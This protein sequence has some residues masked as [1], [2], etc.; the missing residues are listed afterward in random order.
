M[1]Q[2]LLQKINL[3]K[4][5]PPFLEALLEVLAE[6]RAKG[7]D[8]KVYS[9]WRSFA[10]QFELYKTFLAGGAR[11]AAPGRSAHN[12]G[13]A[14]DCARLLPDK[15]LSWDPKDYRV[16]LSVLPNYSLKSGAAYHDMPHINWPGYEGAVELRPLDKL[17]RTTDGSEEDK[18]KAVWRYLDGK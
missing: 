1:P 18:L 8:Y 10:E 5:Y 3:D 4:L 9:G 16:L 6:C 11:A 13:L 2:D 12:F 14:V 15:G 17:Y 7:V